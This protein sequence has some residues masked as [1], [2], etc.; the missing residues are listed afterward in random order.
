MCVCVCVCEYMSVWVS[1]EVLCGAPE[2][3]SGSCREMRSGVTP[4]ELGECD[5][6]AKGQVVCI[7]EGSRVVCRGKSGSP[8]AAP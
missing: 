7:G 1:C 6:R 5:P 4:A 8:G 2:S 3:P